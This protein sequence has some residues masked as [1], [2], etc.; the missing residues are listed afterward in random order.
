MVLLLGLAVGVL[1]AVMLERQA[2]QALTVRRQMD[3]YQEHHA[4]RGLQ[5]VIEAWLRNMR[6]Q[7][8]HDMLGLEGHAL[9]VALADGSEVSVYMRPGQGEILDDMTGLSGPERADAVAIREYFN[10]IVGETGGEGMRRRVGPVRVSAQSAPREVLEA[11]GRRVLRGDDPR[12]LVDEILSARDAD[13]FLD[14]H[15]RN[16]ARRAGL[17]SEQQRRV[18]SLLVASSEY[19]YVTLELRAQPGPNRPLEVVSRYGGYVRIPESRGTTGPRVGFL[20]FEPLGVE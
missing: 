10:A 6:N 2:S 11:V 13:E 4:K 7:P 8:I 15:L 12:S 5:E 20:T 1:S 3:S 14:R 18:R 19:W 17:D 16:A 9:D